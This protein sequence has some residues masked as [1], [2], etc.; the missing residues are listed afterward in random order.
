MFSSR[1]GLVVSVLMTAIVLSSCRPPKPEYSVD[2]VDHV[3]SLDQIR[4]AKG[5]VLVDFYADWCPPC[6]VQGPVIAET[7]ALTGGKA[8]V[9]KVDVD[10]QRDIA[11]RF[12][13]DALPTLVVLKD[14]Q[15]VKRM[16]GLQRNAEKLAN[17]LKKQAQQE[18]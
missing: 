12:Q 3:M 5:V 4:D 8:Q 2:T 18:A 9:L 10:N 14:G 7:K 1:A 16:K 15:E 11:E 6:R 13:I 17:L